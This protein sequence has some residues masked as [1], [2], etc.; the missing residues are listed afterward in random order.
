MNKI[1]IV[2]KDE[3][4]ADNKITNYIASKYLPQTIN[5]ALDS[6]NKLVNEIEIGYPYDIF[7]YLNDL[8]SRNVIQDVIDTDPQPLTQQIILVVDEIDKRF[9]EYT[10]EITEPLSANK[11]EFWWLRIPNKLT[12]GLCD[13]LNSEG[14][15]IKDK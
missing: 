6:W 5:S 2:S 3:I 14:Y 4:D 7:E 9:F 15:I 1:I 10:H 11:R 12:P 13:D 8:F